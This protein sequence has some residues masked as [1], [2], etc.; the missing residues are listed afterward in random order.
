MTRIAKVLLGLA[1][2]AGALAFGARAYAQH[3][4][5]GGFFAHHIQQQIQG[6]LDAAKA[7]P[8]QRAA[9]DAAR[10][11]VMAAFQASQTARQADLEDALAIFSADTLD[12]QALAQHRARREAEG[13]KVG[14]AI[15]QA[16]YDT[17]DALTPPQRQAV[18]DYVRA[19]AAEHERSGPPPFVKKMIEHRVEVALDEIKATPEQRQKLL[20]VKDRLMQSFVEGRPEHKAQMEQA[21]TIFVQDKIDPAKVQALRDT[22][23]ARA[24]QMGDTIVQA[25]TDVH[26]ILT[27][28]QRALLVAWVRAHHKEHHG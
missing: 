10:E 11:H 3:H 12:P 28:D 2:A 15:V 6:A 19:Q 5:C 20:Q 13:I 24:K 26:D 16:L 23:Q 9:V 18:A 17:H 22:H 8:E 27:R 25:F 7:T 1:L 14:D 4:P 21:L